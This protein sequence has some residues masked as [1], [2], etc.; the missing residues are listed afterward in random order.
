MFEIKSVLKITFKN[1]SYCRGNYYSEDDWSIKGIGE[2]V[3]LAIEDMFTKSSRERLHEIGIESSW[4]EVTDIIETPQ[5]IFYSNIT[6]DINDSDV[7]KFG[8]PEFNNKYRTTV[9][10]MKDYCRET[11]YNHP[12]KTHLKK[13]FERMKSMKEYDYK[14]S[15]IEGKRKQLERLKKELENVD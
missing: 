10:L 2:T 3:D 7:Q 15:V 5:G 6:R 13:V 12:K 1:R 11:F 9:D 8:F 4:V 14:K